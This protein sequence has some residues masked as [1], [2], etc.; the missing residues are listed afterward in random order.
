MAIF[1]T[2]FVLK[3]SHNKLVLQFLLFLL[4]LFLFSSISCDIS[5]SKQ[6]QLF[7]HPT[8]NV[9]KSTLFL[10]SLMIGRHLSSFSVVLLGEKLSW[11]RNTL[12]HVCSSCK[13]WNS[14]SRE[15]EI[16]GI[17]PDTYVAWSNPSLQRSCFWTGENSSTTDSIQKKPHM[18]VTVC[19]FVRLCCSSQMLRRGRRTLRRWT[20][21]K[22]RDADWYATAER[23]TVSEKGVLSFVGWR[24]TNK[25]ILFW[26]HNKR[27]G[28]HSKVKVPWCLA[29]TCSG[30]PCS[31]MCWL[32][33][34][35]SLMQLSNL[36]CRWITGLGM[37]HFLVVG[38][39]KVLQME[40][41]RAQISPSQPAREIVLCV[42][43]KATTIHCQQ[44]T[45][46]SQT[47]IVFL[48]SCQT[49]L[50]SNHET[51]LVTQKREHKQICPNH[52]SAT[53]KTTPQI[54]LKTACPCNRS[55][56]FFFS[57]L[58]PRKRKKKNRKTKKRRQ[59][60]NKW[61]SIKIT[62]TFCT[63]L[64][65]KTNKQSVNSLW[66]DE[67][68]VICCNCQ[69]SC[70]CTPAFGPLLLSWNIP[71]LF[72]PIARH[73]SAKLCALCLLFCCFVLFVATGQFPCPNDLFFF[74]VVFTKKVSL[75][76]DKQQ[77]H[78][79]HKELAKIAYL[80]TNDSFRIVSENLI[81]WKNY[82][83]AR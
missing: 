71:F 80:S 43:L 31:L 40:I 37:Q 70:K 75:W 66:R 3:A 16:I 64:I 32:C 28:K 48:L 68:S 22:S 18:Q 1:R 39:L 55:F 38:S 62:R 2:Q 7:F 20:N 65:R 76:P 47:R 17:G 35:E 36:D 8:T 44:K 56:S 11:S 42:C 45:C 50:V 34:L 53:K 4:F 77:R 74:L 12:T 9:R 30:A 81:F 57:P 78:Q 60:N 29:N 46:G 19:V 41:K 23:D 49:R 27:D 67:R 72:L 73:T 51:N 5:V 58:P 33:C 21:W 83:F 24:G 14:K 52:L 82:F 6:K 59:D 61:E 26:F 15:I 69:S 63:W 54:N 10:F 79:D 25:N 13:L